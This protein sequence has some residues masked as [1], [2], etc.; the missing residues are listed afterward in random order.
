M[1]AVF[2]SFIHA[3][4]ITTATAAAA[5]AAAAATFTITRVVFALLTAAS[6]AFVAIAGWCGMGS[7]LR[8][9]TSLICA[10]GGGAWLAWAA[11]TIAALATLA[12]ITAAALAAFTALAATLAVGAITAGLADRFTC[13][14]LWR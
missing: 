14:R 4:A 2:A 7:G 9:G 13:E 5:T 10:I 6:I 11:F 12:T 3:F 8:L 1:R